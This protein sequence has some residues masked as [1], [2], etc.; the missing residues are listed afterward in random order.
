VS[1]R[2]SKGLR[3]KIGIPISIDTTKSGV[4]RRAIEL[5]AEIINDVSGLRFDEELARVAAGTGAGLVSCI[6]AAIRRR[7]RIS[8]RWSIRFAR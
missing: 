5:G 6:R 4:A 1:F 3:G 7:C 2:S 8:R